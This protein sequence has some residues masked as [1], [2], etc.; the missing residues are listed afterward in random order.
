MTTTT[1]TQKNPLLLPEVL[2]RV[3]HFVYSCD[4]DYW[5]YHPEVFLPCILVCRFWHD[6]F[7]P[8]LYS[9]FISGQTDDGSPYHPHIHHL[10]TFV[11]FRPVSDKEL[12]YNVGGSPTASPPGQ[13]TTLRVHQHAEA[14]L[15]LLSANTGSRLRVLTWTASKF[16]VEMP[17]AMVES[18]ASLSGLVSLELDSWKIDRVD[19]LAILAACSSTLEMLS[20]RLISGYGDTP[21]L[22]LE[23]SI[24]S[25]S[26]TT[27]TQASSLL[28]LS[29]LSIQ[30]SLS[31]PRMQRLSE[32]R[33]VLDWHQSPAA[34]HLV[35]LCPSLRS[36]Y[37]NVDVETSDWPALISNLRTFCPR[38]ES[39]EY[40]VGYSMQYETGCYIKSS[41]YASLLRDSTAESEG[42]LRRVILGVKLDEHITEALL[43]HSDTLE[44]MNLEVRTFGPEEVR[45]VGRLL[46]GCR[47]L[48]DVDIEDV[49]KECEAKDL[50]ELT[51][52]AWVC[53]DLKSLTII[54]YSP[55]QAN[56]EEPLTTKRR[57]AN[58]NKLRETKVVKE[59][60]EMKDKLKVFGESGQGWYVKPS[61]R[62]QGLEEAVENMDMKRR[63]MVH[64]MESGLEQVERIQFNESKFYSDERYFS[65]DDEEDKD[66][67]EDE[68]EEE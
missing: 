63:L 23:S 36:L 21:F 2:D 7:L 24:D 65:D 9:T 16:L 67:E 14:M 15:A 64:M 18:M 30:S 35:Q 49:G 56:A 28:S 50:E 48:K 60:A 31:L 3:A 12:P 20:L 40:E 5:D 29:S 66:E 46:A 68:E 39:I 38:L 54:G 37:L 53:R 4:E 1:K 26:T 41:L 11:M 47:R 8:H 17:P 59:Q 34:V 44:V 13:L 51:R 19:L 22:P 61:L 32:L 45:M 43:K 27:P 57:K 6:C 10:R 33:L 62:E 42:Q 25:I 55:Y 52:E 58:N